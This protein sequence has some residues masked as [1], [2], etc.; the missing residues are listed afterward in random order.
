M[1][2]VYEIWGNRLCLLITGMVAKHIN[3]N[4]YEYD[5]LNY[6]IPLEPTSNQN[7]TILNRLGFNLSF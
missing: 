7:I 2:T 4:P 6:E 5:V 3:C 1:S